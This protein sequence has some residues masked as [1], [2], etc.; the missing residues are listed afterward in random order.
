[1]AQEHLLIGLC[2]GELDHRKHRSSFLT[3]K[4]GGEPD[5]PPGIMRQFPYCACCSAP[6]AHVVQVYCPM[7]GSPY[8][9][10]LNL[11]ACCQPGCSG[12]PGSWTVLRSQCME[13]SNPSFPP[14]VAVPSATV[15]C[16]SADDWGMEGEEG[17][18]LQ[19]QSGDLQTEGVLFGFFCSMFKR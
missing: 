11:F 9:R 3:N 8:H 4:I 12:Q 18:E 19:E 13:A 15:W 2:D 16:E 5:W 14:Q 6:L 10:N 17:E 1:M 7:Q